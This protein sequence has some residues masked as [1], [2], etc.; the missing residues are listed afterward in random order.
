MSP[1]FFLFFVQVFCSFSTPV[2][3]KLCEI[4]QLAFVTGA[5]PYKPFCQLA[6]S[7]TRG[8]Y[9]CSA[10][11]CACVCVCLGWAGRV[12]VCVLCELLSNRGHEW[13]G[14]LFLCV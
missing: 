6:L 9:Q 5:K 10:A 8:K 12:S 13:A 1:G 7:N 14:F 11:K 2:I 4:S 3:H